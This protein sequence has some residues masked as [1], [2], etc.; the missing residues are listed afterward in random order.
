MN[1][2]AVFLDRDGVINRALVRDGLPYAPTCEAQLQIVED[3]PAALETLHAHGFPLIVV[4]NQPDVARG[5]V[6]RETVESLH[7]RRKYYVSGCDRGR[8]RPLQS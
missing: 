4:T 7:A 5:T 1:R 3:V 6:T 8:R 2:P